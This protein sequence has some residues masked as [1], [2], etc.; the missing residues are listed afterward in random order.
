M[1]LLYVGLRH[2]YGDPSRGDSFEHETFVPALRDFADNFIYF[3]LDTMLRSHCYSGMNSALWEIVQNDRPDLLFCV[4]FENQLDRAVLR[5]ISMETRTVTVNWFCDD[6]WRFESFSRHWAPCFNWVATT[7]REAFRSYQLLDGVRPILTQWAANPIPRPLVL[8]TMRDVVFVGQRRPVRERYLNHLRDR[9]IQVDVYGHGWPA[10]R[11]PRAEIV[12]LM[13][14][15]R[16]GL[17]FSES[18]SA[19]HRLARTR[20]QLKARPFELGACGTAIVSEDDPEI[21]YF[22]EAGREMLV[23]R[24]RRQ[25]Y[26]TIRRL[27]DN[28]DERAT[29]AAAGYERSIAEHTYH[30]RISRILATMGVDVRQSTAME[31]SDQR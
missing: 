27:L 24:S 21:R 14:S 4:L 6:H 25:L 9:G 29:I 30:R 19:S 10:G 7:S 18:S 13:A 23:F 2:D 26:S 16:I 22:Y 15:S 20:A 11:L 1:K 17:N 12:D 3:E 8:P 5:R 28:E 31:P